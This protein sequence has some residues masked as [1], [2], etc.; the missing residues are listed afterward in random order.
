MQEWQQQ[1]QSMGGGRRSGLQLGMNAKTLNLGIL[2]GALFAWIGQV[3]L[4]YLPEVDFTASAASIL[5][6]QEAVVSATK[7]GNF[8]LATG[9]FLVVAAAMLIITMV[10]LEDKNSKLGY[11]ILAGLAL[12]AI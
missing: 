8:L 4:C 2:L 5:K 9:A 11:L 12:W 1:S 10:P 3:R 6:A 7:M